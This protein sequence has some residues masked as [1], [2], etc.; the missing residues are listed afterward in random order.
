MPG[1]ERT[2]ANPR[3]KRTDVESARLLGSLIRHGLAA[4]RYPAE[5]S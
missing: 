4:Q 3:L 2:R 5:G 1:I